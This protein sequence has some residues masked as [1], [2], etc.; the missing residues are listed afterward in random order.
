MASARLTSPS[1]RPPTARRR[2]VRRFATFSSSL[3]RRTSSRRSTSAGE[4]SGFSATGTGLGA[5]SMPVPSAGGGGGGRAGGGGGG[6]TPG[7][8]VGGAFGS[9][10]SGGFPASFG[11]FEAFSARSRADAQERPFDVAPRLRPVVAARRRLAPG[12]ERVLRARDRELER[13]RLGVLAL[14][15]LL[16][17][18]A[19]RERGRAPQEVAP[20]LEVGA[21]LARRLGLGLLGVVETPALQGLEGARVERDRFRAIVPVAAAREEEQQGDETGHRD[22]ECSRRGARH[23]R[24]RSGRPSSTRSRSTAASSGHW[25]RFSRRWRASA[26]NDF[27]A[28]A[29]TRSS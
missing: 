15:H 11:S 7:F 13:G 19:L 27:L 5:A 1:P 16:G 18:L 20:R 29:T 21:A 14:R 4:R 17:E 3:A 6:G 10:G 12:R 24:L 26:A 25:K 23:R 9:P 22:A 2:S 8:G 28:M